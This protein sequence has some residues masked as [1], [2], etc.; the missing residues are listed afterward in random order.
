MF[1]LRF[2]PSVHHIINDNDNYKI[3]L[4]RN[5]LGINFE[6]NYVYVYSQKIENL[7]P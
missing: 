3:Q 2:F 4:N 6:K 1:I 5:I 7:L